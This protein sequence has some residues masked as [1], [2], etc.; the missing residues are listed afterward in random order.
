MN[1]FC[2]IRRLENY[3]RRTVRSNS[4]HPPS[5][6]GSH[7]PGLSSIDNDNWEEDERDE[8]G[9]AIAAAHKGRTFKRGDSD[10]DMQGRSAIQRS[11]G[12]AISPTERYA[13]HHPSA[14]FRKIERASRK[15]TPDQNFS[16]H[17]G[18][19][20]IRGQEEEFSQSS[21]ISSST[22]DGVCINSSD[23][24]A[25][26]EATS[27]LPPSGITTAESSSSRHRNPKTIGK[28]KRTYESEL[29]ATRCNSPTH[30]HV[31]HGS[32]GLADRATISSK[33]GVTGRSKRQE[34]FS[35]VKRPSP[36]HH[37][38][39]SSRLRG[40]EKR[41]AMK[42]AKEKAKVRYE[43]NHLLRPLQ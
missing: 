35:S 17:S 20:D 9:V 22:V 34:S 13:N 41:H 32:R 18:E 37:R 3:D 36:R 16:V 29:L 10:V 14:S 33:S 38:R 42:I 12:R 4:P 2:F 7:R 15:H 25:A 1:L 24:S 23:A 39:E 43:K 19:T 21:S 30:L 8:N 28:S 27:L 6:R 5:S 11:A 40:E 26:N 31:Q